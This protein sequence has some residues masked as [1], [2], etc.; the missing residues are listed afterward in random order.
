MLSLT[1]QEKANAYGSSREMAR[2]TPE[3]VQKLDRAMAI[4][5][6]N[7]RFLDVTAVAHI[8]KTFGNLEGLK[9]GKEINLRNGDRLTAS[10]IKYLYVERLRQAKTKSLEVG[11]TPHDEE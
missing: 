2:I 8:R 4:E 1:I 7:G 11:R 5:T 6:H 3:Q 10:D 9:D